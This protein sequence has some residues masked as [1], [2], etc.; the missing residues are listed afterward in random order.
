MPAANAEP[1]S[2]PLLRHAHDGVNMQSEASK[3]RGQGLH[4][5]CQPAQTRF[6]ILCR[7]LGQLTSRPPSPCIQTET[8]FECTHRLA[9]YVRRAPIIIYII[10]TTVCTAASHQLSLGVFTGA[11]PPLRAPASGLS[12]HSVQQRAQPHTS[13]SLPSSACCG[14]G[15]AAP[16][17]QHGRRGLKKGAAWC[18]GR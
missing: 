9:S 2:G 14:G 16:P 17:V 6:T 10:H 3:H 8:V 5:R 7:I 13:A 4:C 12:T 11:P 18:A 15:T 1:A